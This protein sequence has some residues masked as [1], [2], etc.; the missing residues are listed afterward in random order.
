MT[1]ISRS[2]STALKEWFV[3]IEALDQGLQILI[4]R[5]GGIHKDDKDFRM[6]KPEFMLLPTFEHQAID[7]LKP[8]YRT[9]L[10]NL[11]HNSETNHV[12]ISNW[13]KTID[14]YEVRDET[15]LDRLSN[16][17]I[18]EDS[19]ARKRLNWRPKKP[20]TV[21]M[22]RIYKLEKPQII[23]IVSEYLGCKSW[24]KLQTPIT[25]TNL[26]PTLSDKDFR[27]QARAIR[28]I[29]TG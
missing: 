16:F 13:A 24:V 1:V 29:I 17:H 20:L 10:D 23:P 8:K 28:K 5:K 25:L 9:K 2:T 11:P 15:T 26:K 4:L 21:A 12:S 7:L 19:Y 6:I 22:L 3:A 18:W 27:S 14:T